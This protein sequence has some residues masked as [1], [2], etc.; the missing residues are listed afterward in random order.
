MNQDAALLT[1]AEA[2]T[3]LECSA[4]TVIRRAED[5]TLSYLR[6]LPGPNGDYLFDRA[7]VL[8]HK[9]EADKAKAAS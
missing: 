6:K 3:I 8:R 7:E 5:G 2:G 4:R 1:A 9:A